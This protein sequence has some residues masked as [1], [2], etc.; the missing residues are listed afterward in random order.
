[1][2]VGCG[3]PEAQGPMADDTG[4]VES[5]LY[6]SPDSLSGL[7]GSYTR[8]WPPAAPEELTSMTL[9]GVEYEDRVEG[10]YSR[11]VSRL[12]PII[13]CNTEYGSFWALPNNPA[14]GSVIVF[15]DLAGQERDFYAITQIQ[16]S[17]FTGKITS[18]VLVKG[19]GTNPQPFTMNRVGF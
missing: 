8:Y 14:V 13:G 17:A 9:S 3:A 19:G 6:E 10:S 11:T 1:M 18:I 12:C 5:A 16:R 7:L 15:R 4:A 2:L